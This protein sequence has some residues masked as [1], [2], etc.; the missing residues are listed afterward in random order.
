MRVGRGW[1]MA[2]SLANMGLFFGYIGPLQVLLPNQVQDIDSAQGAQARHRHR[3]R[4]G[5]RAGHRPRRRSPG[6]RDRLAVRPGAGQ[7]RAGVAP[8]LRRDLA[9][10]MARSPAFA[11]AATMIVIFAYRRTMIMSVS[12]SSAAPASK[13]S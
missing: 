1:I 7:E 8:V 11:Y 6:G 2:L 3:Y 13:R 5:R 9:A 4:R 12:H 10:A